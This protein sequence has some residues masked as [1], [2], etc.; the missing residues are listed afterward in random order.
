MKALHDAQV[1]L[2]PRVGAGFL[3]HGLPAAGR[4]D[5][6]AVQRVAVSPALLIWT[7]CHIAVYALIVLERMA[8]ASR[9]S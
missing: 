4:G 3:S 9:D 1:V 2:V 6:C 5:L 8:R 7:C